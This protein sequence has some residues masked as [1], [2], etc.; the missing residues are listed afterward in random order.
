MAETLV[1]GATGGIGAAL[2]GAS[3]NRGDCVTAL[4]RS[5]NGLDV[6]DEDAVMRV[7]G[8]LDQRFDRIIIASGALEID[9]AGPEKS[10][11]AI[12]WK[13]MMDQMAV[14]AVGPALVL[15]HVPDLLV[16][17]AGQ[18]AVLSARVGSIGDN[19]LGG[20]I[21]YRA[22]KAAVNQIIRTTSI[23]LA[24]T[25]PASICVALHPGTVATAFTEKYLGRH[26]S[27][28]P[29]QA[30]EN[31]L[32]VLDGL[33]PEDTGGFFDYAGKPVPW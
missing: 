7:L 2:A 4:S 5:Q 12:S 10:I 22:A 26:P 29:K 24:R 20:W 30:A 11:K 9:G 1:I 21:S 19:A 15:R 31:L 18:V 14:N 25:H 6:T 13:A 27:V 8:G 16:R 23:D 32:C 3:E 17:Q 33:T 28:T